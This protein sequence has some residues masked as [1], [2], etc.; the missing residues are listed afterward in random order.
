VG[1]DAHECA[2]EFAHVAFDALSHEFD[3][4]GFQLGVEVSLFAAEDGHPGLIVW[5]LNL[6]G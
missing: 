4:P 1:D 2:F 6:G 5:D 3:D